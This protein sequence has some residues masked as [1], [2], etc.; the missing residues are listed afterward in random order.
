MFLVKI[1]LMV[2][3]QDFLYMKKNLKS[4]FELPNIYK[5]AT[6]FIN[7]S[8]SNNE[9]MIPFLDGS[10]WNQ[11]KCSFSDKIVFSNFLYYD[12]DEL[13]NPL[14][15]HSGIYKMVCIYYLI[16]TLP[17]EYLSTLENIFISLH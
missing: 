7:D 4:F 6:Q 10:T 17:P 14:G 11:M 12:D 9:T 2:S 16:A 3:V 1:D 8:L 13:G 15:S 5:I